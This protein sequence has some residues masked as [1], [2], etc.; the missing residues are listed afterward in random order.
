MYFKTAHVLIVHVFRNINLWQVC[1]AKV[2]IVCGRV[3]LKADFPEDVMVKDA[4]DV[5]D[6]KMDFFSA[7]E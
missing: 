1:S 7:G 3:L 6:E 4:L 2:S 5:L